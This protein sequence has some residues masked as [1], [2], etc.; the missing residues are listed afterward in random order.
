MLNHVTMM[1]SF[2]WGI[3]PGR[4]RTQG[5][6]CSSPCRNKKNRVDYAV[7]R[8]NMIVPKCAGLWGHLYS[9]PATDCQFN[10]NSW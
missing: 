10:M 7:P 9:L 4:A 8:W 6:V 3:R 2:F 1:G 5:W